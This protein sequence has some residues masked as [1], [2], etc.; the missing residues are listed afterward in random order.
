MMQALEHMHSLGLVHMDVKGSNILIDQA[1][2]WYLGDFGSTR[3]IGEL[4]ITTTPSFYPIDLCNKPAQPKYDWFMLLVTILIEM[5]PK[6]HEWATELCEAERN[7]VTFSRVGKAL[8]KATDSADVD[9]P[10]KGMLAELAARAELS[11]GDTGK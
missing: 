4:V 9:E 7:I 3:D 8:G 10:L 6:K 1:G 11:V 5:M 2:E